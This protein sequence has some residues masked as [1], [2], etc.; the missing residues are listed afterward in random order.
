M[1]LF[2]HNIWDYLLYKFF[3]RYIRHCYLIVSCMGVIKC[4]ACLHRMRI[5]RPA[6]DSATSCAGEKEVG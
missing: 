1:I 4:F 5:T 2:S 3:V 6:T